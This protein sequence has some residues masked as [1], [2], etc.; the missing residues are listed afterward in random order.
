MNNNYKLYVH[1]NLLN[2]K[3]YVGITMREPKIRWGKDGCG[4]KDQPKFYNAIQKYGW[5][6]FSHTILFEELTEEE[7]LEMES[8]YIQYYNA[9]NNGYNILLQGI[10]S[11]PRHK[12]VYCLTTQTKYASIK[13]ASL[14]TGVESSRIIQNCKGIIGPTKGLQWTYWDDDNNTYFPPRIFYPK[15]R[16]S[17]QIYCVELDKWYESESQLLREMQLDKS[18]L[19]KAL[20]GTRNGINGYHFVRAKEMYKIPE[21]MK[22]QTGKNRRVYCIETERFFNNLT[23]AAHFCQ[24]TEQSVMKNCQGKTKSCNNYH[25]KYQEDVDFDEIMRQRGY[26]IVKQGE[27]EDEGVSTT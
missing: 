6:N 24:V 9:I 1:T 17:V 5:E 27:Q 20:N 11:Y 21:I 13:E 2:G 14:A 23:E 18:G 22:K 3:S 25:F 15:K 26:D 8:F 19:I 16:D 12:P 10:K 7:A 4:Y